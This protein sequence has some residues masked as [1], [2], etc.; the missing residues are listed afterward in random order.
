MARPAVSTLR[1]T[2]PGAVSSATPSV[3]EL[4]GLP[5]S[6]VYPSLD[7]TPSCT[8]SSCLNGGKCTK[9]GTT[10]SC[11]CPAG[12]TGQKCEKEGRNKIKWKI[13][14]NLH[15]KKLKSCVDIF[16]STKINFLALRNKFLIRKTIWIF[17][18]VQEIWEN[19]SWFENIFP[20]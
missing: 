18:F 3:S 8:S 6:I 2:C 15:Y 4:L 9:R 5:L 19:I 20:V 10:Y 17:F 14:S 13:K 11:S 7:S 12:F 16:S 1:G